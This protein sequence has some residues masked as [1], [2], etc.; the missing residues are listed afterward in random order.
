MGNWK[1]GKKG[2][3]GKGEG[4]NEVKGGRVR[5]EIALYSMLCILWIAFY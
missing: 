1:R 5:R 4:G 3:R 2:I